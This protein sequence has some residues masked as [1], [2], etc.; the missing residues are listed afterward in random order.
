MSKS[1]TWLSK[2]LGK[3]AFQYKKHVAGVIQE[4]SLVFLQKIPDKSV[5]LVL[6]DPPYFIDKM[7]ANWNREKLKISQGKAKV[8]G[9]MPV[10]MKFDPKQGVQ[11]QAYLEGIF[12]ECERILKPGGFLVSFSQARLYHRLAMAAENSGFEIRDMFA[13]TYEGQAKAF[14]QDHFVKKMDLSDE[15]KA[16][17]IAKLGGRKTPQLKPMIE[18]MVFAQKPKEGTFIENWLK[19]SIG[20]IDTSVQWNGKFPGNVMN[21]AKPNADERGDDNNH[22]TV[23]P[24]KVLQHLI[25]VLTPPG[26]IVVDPFAGSS[27]TQLAALKAGRHALGCERE[28]EDF[29]T[30]KRRLALLSAKPQLKTQ[31]N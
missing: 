31:D 4:D 16:Q 19:H 23:K 24:Q 5:D 18:P 13:W 9:S 20:L 1:P 26:A 2:I 8:V 15:D 12:K 29:E 28:E 10:G 14:T 7:G 6:T 30:S 11:L 17:I 21:C 3:E 27:S 25:E 22:L